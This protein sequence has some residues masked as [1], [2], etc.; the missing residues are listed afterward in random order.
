MPR[1]SVFLSAGKDFYIWPAETSNW[2]LQPQNAVA[3]L[4]GMLSSAYRRQV[5]A[6]TPF[7]TYPKGEAIQLNRLYVKFQK[8]A[9]AVAISLRAANLNATVTVMVSRTC[10]AVCDGRM[11]RRL[12]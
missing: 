6:A 9:A 7:T 3:F 5:E 11:L 8:T 12:L 2:L 10:T 1:T 4:C